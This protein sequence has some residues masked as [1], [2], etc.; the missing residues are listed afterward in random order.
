VNA[1]VSHPS[2]KGTLPGELTIQDGRLQ[3]Q[4]GEVSVEM[5]LGGLV[6]E[7]GG[8][9]HDHFFLRHPSAEGWLVITS[10]LAIVR[11]LSTAT[12]DTARQINAASTARV[13]MGRRLY[14]A[15]ALALAILAGCVAL[16]F[17]LKSPL[18]GMVTAKLPVS[19]EIKFG[20]QA[21]E[22]LA[23]QGKV[24]EDPKWR[25]RLDPVVARLKT[26][27]TNAGYDFQFH[28][29]EAKELNAFAIPGGHIVVYTGLLEAVERPE[30]LA[31]VLAHEMAHVIRR[32]SLR[33]VVESAGLG[34]MVQ[35]L[36]GDATGLAAVAT[37]SSRWL[38][39]QK[40]SRDTERE[41]DDVGWD[42]LVEAKINPR[43]LI[44]FFGKMRK[45]IGK[46]L[47]AAAVD[48]SLSVLSTHPATPERI[49]HL[50]K[51]WRGLAD[52]KGFVKIGEE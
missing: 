21:Y 25:A 39:Q 42:Y 40:F 9:Y 15:G 32:H 29:M 49:A 48:G 23:A 19:W 50:E 14:V 24:T 41:A 7:A 27:V 47:T 16:L 13:S 11:E 1:N 18:A 17:A 33:N 22:Q 36:F 30:E 31:G 8:N 35:T 28:V 4:G 34:L 2:F 52:K 3:F 45:E 6:I 20:N 38:L 44:D 43:G 26:A 51:K 46:D 12:T 37:G 10:D 5:S